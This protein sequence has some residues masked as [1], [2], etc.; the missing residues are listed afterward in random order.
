M[1]IIIGAIAGVLVFLPLVIK[2]ET[3]L[4]RKD[5][6]AEVKDWHNFKSVMEKKS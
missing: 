1:Q 2:L 3:W 5:D 4:N 6:F